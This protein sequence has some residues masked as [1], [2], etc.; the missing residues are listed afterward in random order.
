MLSNLKFTGI[1]LI[2]LYI[3]LYYVIQRIL[4]IILKNKKIWLRRGLAALLSLL[5][6]IPVSDFYSCQAAVVLH[7]AVISAMV[8]IV[9]LI[10][11]KTG[12]RLRKSRETAWRSGGI[13]A[14][15]T[16][17]VIGYAYINMHRVTATEYTVST[18]KTIREEGYRIVFLSDLHFGTT[19]DQK[20]LEKYCRQMSDKKPDA[21]ILGGDIVDEFTSLA[22]VQEAFQT[23]GEINSAYGVYYV[24]GNHDKGKY[25]DHCDFTENELLQIIRECGIRILADETVMLNNELSISGRQDRSDARMSHTKRKSPKKLLQDTPDSVFHIL[26]DHQPRGM[27]TNERAGYDLML[28]GHT[29]A[30]QMWPV[31]L[32]TTLFDKDTVNYGQKKFGTMNLIVSSG[33]AGWRY[34]LRTGKHC[35]YVVVHIEQSR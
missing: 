32:V 4:K 35:E 9:F 25:S 15:I 16:L 17:T 6:T 33:I 22:Q 5:M 14:A 20:Q 10:M 1:L 28:S 2:P 23:L 27:E 26:A 18:E 21:A 34:P 19:M 13:A 8:D 29:H 11:K 24:Y 3:Y 31:G 7:F 12:C 30:G